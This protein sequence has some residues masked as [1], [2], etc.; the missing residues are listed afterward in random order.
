[1][2][3]SANALAPNPGW[4]AC[5]LHLALLTFPL[6]FCNLHNFFI[7]TY[8][9]LSLKDVRADLDIYQDLHCVHCVN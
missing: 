6:R 4:I 8:S 2:A 3:R 9:R 7:T 5:F 1:M